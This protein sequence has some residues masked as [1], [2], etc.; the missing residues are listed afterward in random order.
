[1]TAADAADADLLAAFADVDDV[2]TRQI[3][4]ARRNLPPTDL[5]LLVEPDEVF[6]IALDDRMTRS[7]RFSANQ[8]GKSP[9]PSCLR[10]ALST[11]LG[12]YSTP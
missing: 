2:A 11:R 3:R 12:V 6:V 10:V 8:I 9:A 5:E 7:A 1:M 4:Q